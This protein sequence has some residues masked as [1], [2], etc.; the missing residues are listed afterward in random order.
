MASEGPVGVVDFTTPADYR[1]SKTKLRKKRKKVGNRRVVGE[2]VSKRSTSI[3][4][5]NSGDAE[6]ERAERLAEEELEGTCSWPSRQEL[7]SSVNEVLSFSDTFYLLLFLTAGSESESYEGSESYES[8]GS[9]E[10]NAD[11]H[12][13]RASMAALLDKATE[14]SKPVK[15]LAKAP[16]MEEKAEQKEE[17]A[18]REAV[19][20]T[21]KQALQKKLFMNRNHREPALSNS[22]LEVNLRKI[23]TRGIVKLFNAIKE[24][25]KL[26]PL[27]PEAERERSDKATKQRFM[28]T[29]QKKLAKNSANDGL[30]DDEAP[31]QNK[32]A[33]DAAASS[34]N[35]KSPAGPGAGRSWE[36]LR[37]DYMLGAKM[38]DW[39]KESDEE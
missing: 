31:T 35:S 36:V 15:M 12:S 9:E 19:K 18:K 16:R 29:L 32:K 25:Q 6:P 13:F 4:A 5:P 23:G 30:S 37:D 28:D 17:R 38:R 22:E 2:K 33:K 26:V 20:L 24:H 10:N 14:G 11:M 34:S 39:N 8:D 1:V 3:D 27:A 21:Q 7:R